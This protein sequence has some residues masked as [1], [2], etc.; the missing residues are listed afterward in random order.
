LIDAPLI[1]WMWRNYGDQVVEDAADRLWAL[2][3]SFGLAVLD[4]GAFAHF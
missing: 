2:H 3:S 4:K 1:G